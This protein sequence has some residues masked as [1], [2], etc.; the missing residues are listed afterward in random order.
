MKYG[1]EEYKEMK[2]KL[3]QWLAQRELAEELRPELEE[4]NEKLNQNPQDQET[5][6]DLYDRFHKDLE[7]GTGGL[8]GIMGA[9]TN[10]MNVYSVR[11][12]T[13]G[14]CAY[15]KRQ[16]GEQEGDGKKAARNP[17]TGGKHAACEKQE[18]CAKQDANGKR[19]CVAISYDSRIHS[20][21]FADTAAETFAANGFDVRL[22]AELMPTPALS[23]AVR[24]FHCVGGVMVTAS[25][26]P[27][28]YNGY[29]VY[30]EQ[31]CQMN[32]E[33]SEQV[34][35]LVEAREFFEP[36]CLDC[37]C[38]RGT[39][40]AIEE[41]DIQAFLDAVQVESAKIDC[42]DLRVTY[43]PLNGTGNRCVRS[44]L[45][46]IGVG[47]VISVPSQ[48]MPDGNFP[49]CPYPNPE[50]KEA[51]AEGL[52]VCQAASPKPDL[53]LAT[54]PDCDRAGIAVWNPKRNDY[55]L[56]SGNETGCLLLDFLCQVRKN[57]KPG[58]RPMGDR[59]VAVTTVVTSKMVDALAKFYGIQLIHV[60]TGFKFIGEQ[61]SILEEKGEADRYLFG[62]EESYGYLSGPY[63]RDKDAVNASM[64]ICQMTAYYKAQGKTLADRMEE[65]YAQ[66][67]Y[68]QNTMMEFAFEGVDGMATME[69][70]MQDFR[71]HPWEKAAGQ[72][73]TAIADY[74][75]SVRRTAEETAGMLTKETRIDLP[76]S[77]VLEYV[78]EDGSGFIV[79]PSGTEP[80]LKVYLFA[81]GDTHQ[82][83][84]AMV[85][86]MK[87]DIGGWM[88]KYE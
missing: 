54:D 81:K 2:R 66:L 50:K 15:L 67:G 27:A 37:G 32:L 60:L 14:L 7:F 58:V 61:V 35:N 4:L 47:T 45:S 86:L 52:A 68:Y 53:L 41:E 42:S 71:S 87:T 22:Y 30:N 77:D 79:R 59:P 48:E 8:R 34:I 88:K 1:T 31:G 6:D 25:H 80:K 83:S 23:F 63:V 62:F 11:R 43:T 39:V 69:T 20:K 73:V 16:G 19:P 33:A 17:K 44:I 21:L 82:A 38:E 75:K 29:K 10:R 51:L 70:I 49:T 46:R 72:N 26:N 13:Q 40:R 85:D 36:D 5:L 28:K 76:K 9:G 12:T 64:L 24:H 65:L 55:Q 57:P 18:G 3:A 84:Q 56:M 78:L 74:L